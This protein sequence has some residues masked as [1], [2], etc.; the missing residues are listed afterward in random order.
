MGA[1]GVARQRYGLDMVPGFSSYLQG[2][3]GAPPPVGQGGGAPAGVLGGLGAT[4]PPGAPAGS[5]P[6]GRAAAPGQPA[7]SEDPYQLG[8]QTAN[9]MYGIPLPPLQ[10][11]AVFSSKD[12]DAALK[13]AEDARRQNIYEV[14]STMPWEQAVRT[15]YRQGYLDVARAGTLLSTPADKQAQLIQAMASPDAYMGLRNAGIRGGVQPT[16]EGDSRLRA[17]HRSGRPAAGGGEW[18]QGVGRGSSG[19]RAEGFRHTRYRR[20]FR[21][22]GPRRPACCPGRGYD[23]ADPRNETALASIGD[24]RLPVTGRDGSGGEQRFCAGA[25]GLWDGRERRLPGGSKTG[26]VPDGAA[27]EIGMFQ[28]SLALARIWA[29][30]PR[31]SA[32]RRRTRWPAPPISA[33]R[34]TGAAMSRLASKATTPA[35]RPGRLPTTSRSGGGIPAIRSAR[36][37]G[38]W[39]SCS[40]SGRHCDGGHCCPKRSAPGNE[41]ACRG[42]GRQ[43]RAGHGR[44]PAGSERHDDH[45]AEQRCG[46]GPGPGR[47]DGTGDEPGR[48]TA[49]RPDRRRSAECGRP[50]DRRQ[51]ADPPIPRRGIESRDRPAQH[52]AAGA[53]ELPPVHRRRE[54]QGGR[55]DCAWHGPGGRAEG[56]QVRSA[57]TSPVSCGK[58]TRAAA[59]TSRG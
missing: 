17:D 25:G 6:A 30:R 37:R 3:P 5:L 23:P 53:G 12:P 13:S 42:S 24:P 43:R 21:R 26:P 46:R 22:S 1:L 39:V 54:R 4:A 16:P 52:M 40:G 14:A 18:R 41:A 49:R 47:Q 45:A 57:D 7:A 56:G 9:T 8:P 2:V 11:V 19:W 29:T 38:P 31:R 36:R 35:T 34:S 59:S 20:R 50:W 10:A 48:R 28:S 15:L 27:G 58:A 44:F 55:A 33:S 32:T 51:D